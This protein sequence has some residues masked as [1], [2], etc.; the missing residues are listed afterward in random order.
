MKDSRYADATQAIEVVL[1]RMDEALDALAETARAEEPLGEKMSLHAWGSMYSMLQDYSNA[2]TK[3]R[4]Q[5]RDAGL[6]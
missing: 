3:W 6:M 4:R 5:A 2:A 1:N